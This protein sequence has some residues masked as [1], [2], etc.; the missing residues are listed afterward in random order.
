VVLPRNQW[1]YQY[2]RKP[3]ASEDSSTGE[4]SESTTSVD[5]PPRAGLK[6]KIC[7]NTLYFTVRS[8]GR[9]AEPH[10]AGPGE[11]VLAG[12]AWGENF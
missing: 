3:T 10:A 8:Q 7:Y 9:Q 11:I 1:Y 12:P 6:T 4:A 2:D 5:E